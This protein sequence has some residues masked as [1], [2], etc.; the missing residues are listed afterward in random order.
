MKY[1][2]VTSKSIAKGMRKA[3][4]ELSKDKTLLAHQTSVGFIMETYKGPPR[5]GFVPRGVQVF[6]KV[7]KYDEALLKRD[8]I[9]GGLLEYDKE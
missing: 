3:L 6:I 9:S 4:L 8:H 7:S 2:P 1:P 5:A